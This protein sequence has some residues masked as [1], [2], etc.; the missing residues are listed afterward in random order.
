MLYNVST[1]CQ[2]QTNNNGHIIYYYP[3]IAIYY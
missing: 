3:L 1:M 2:Y